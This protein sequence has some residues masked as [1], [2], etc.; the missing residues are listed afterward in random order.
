MCLFVYHTGAEGTVLVRLVNG[1][2]NNEGRVEIRVNGTW[3][4]ICDGYFSYNDALVVCRMLG[5]AT[6]DR[7]ARPNAFGIGTYS[8]LLYSVY[9]RGTEQ[10]ILDCY[11]YGSSCYQDVSAGVLCS[12]GKLVVCVCLCWLL[13]V[14]RIYD[15]FQCFILLVCAAMATCDGVTSQCCGYQ[16]ST[17]NNFTFI[18]CMCCFYSHHIR[19]L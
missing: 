14:M 11:Q 6:A 13:S 5:Y 17:C 15:K 1:S 12:D 7:P 19:C 4:T 3:G 18:Y 10:S 2:N 8:P 16:M 9:C